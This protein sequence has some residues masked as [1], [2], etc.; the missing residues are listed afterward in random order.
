MKKCDSPAGNTED[1]SSAS[2]KGQEKQ[3]PNRILQAWLTLD[4]GP[5]FPRKQ[6][7]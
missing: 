2:E 3:P 7:A 4:P 5:R 6:S 1:S